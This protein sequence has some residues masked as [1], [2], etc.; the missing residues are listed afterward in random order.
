MTGAGSF[1][2]VYIRAS[3]PIDVL[4]AAL[5]CNRHVCGS[6]ISGL[7]LGIAGPSGRAV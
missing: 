1:I 7:I 2:I 5:H 6:E 4:I 3:K